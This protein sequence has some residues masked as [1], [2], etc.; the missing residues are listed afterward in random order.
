MQHTISESL[1]QKT[2]DLIASGFDGKSITCAL[3]S[4]VDAL[5]VEAFLH[6]LEGVDARP[7]LS[8]IA[9]GGYGRR[10]LA[11]Y[12]DI[13]IMLLG[14]RKDS[15]TKEAAQSVLYR[16]W[17]SGLHISPSFRTL[18]ECIEDA[19]RDLK[20]RTALIESRL[21]SGSQSLFDEYKR[22]TYPKILYKDK[23]RFVTDMMRD[24]EL[25]H[26]SFGESPYLLEPNVKEGRGG[27]RD[28]HGL[29]WLAK[30]AL[31]VGDA[32]ALT[33]TLGA[34]DFRRLAGAQDFLLKVRTCLHAISGRGNDLLSFD[35]H[36]DLATML[37]IRDGVRLH[38]AEILMT[39]YYR[40][41]TDVESALRKVRH[42]CGE[43]QYALPSYFSV[44]KVNPRFW[45]WKNQLAVRDR[46][47]LGEPEGIMEA[48]SL[49]AATGKRFSEQVRD[50]VR[51]TLQR[52][53]RKRWLAKHVSQS[54]LTILRG[55]G[56]YET[57]R[58]MH[59]SGVLSKVIPE[60]GRLSH[61]VVHEPYHRYT[62]DEHSLIAVRNL[63]LLKLK[64]DPRLAHLSE[65][66]AT[67]RQE[68][69]YLAALLHDVGK[70]VA[71][72][73]EET[74]FRI[75][76]DILGRLDLPQDDKKRIE[77]LV[78]NHILLSRVTLT[79]DPDAHETIAQISEIV[80]QVDNLDALYLMTYA[81]MSAVNPHFWT[82]WKA[83]L[84]HNVYTLAK[85]HLTGMAR[86]YYETADEELRRFIADM[87]GRYLVSHRSEAIMADYRLASGYACGDLGLSVDERSDGTAEVTILTSDRPGLF[88]KI[89]GVL[90]MRGFHILRAR[91]YTGKSGLVLDKLVVSNWKELWWDGMEA[92]IRDEMKRAIVS[93]SPRVP[94]YAGHSQRSR[95]FTGRY[96][97]LERS[98]VCDN[99]TSD[100]YTLLELV[101]P[102]RL[103]LLHDVATQIHRHDIDIISAIINT[104]ELVARDVFYLQ[105]RGAKLDSETLMSVLIA[106]SLSE[107]LMPDVVGA[108]PL[109]TT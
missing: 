64:R 87:P 77:F 31:K 25:R 27:L 21:V 89:V 95:E 82:A 101:L 63:E 99:E 100:D 83:H 94:S 30:V 96:R 104:E 107:G 2:R 57:L 47:I 13:D 75:M 88:S 37:R 19:M 1:S 102:D 6:S 41:A 3:S 44:K 78:R 28:I 90:S 68:V 61:L 53:P 14:K 55:D 17:D 36:D 93:V 73:H 26:R 65:I 59:D 48:F 85:D 51:E 60:F 69:L 86:Q 71:A 20:T 84:L 9:V 16:L 91:L 56:V 45:L 58:E 10:E 11:P 105:Q 70:G 43:R 79:R 52:I 23:K 106:L 103:G 39:L 62:V 24:I 72:G 76:K 7:E 4:S 29:W 42:L 40:K 12:S 38:A 67:A 97:R 8:L 33:R 108:P 49:F 54:F 46:A 80:E 66:F 15:M 50:T 92:Q 22:D 98:L 32:D 18:S 74:G 34:P 35:V 109:H 5:L 81:D